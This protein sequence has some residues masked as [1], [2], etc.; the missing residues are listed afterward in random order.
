MESPSN[1]AGQIMI[2]K[3]NL[4]SP[5]QRNLS[6]SSSSSILVHVLRCCECGFE[7]IVRDRFDTHNPCANTIDSF[8]LYTCSRCGA[9]STSQTLM[10]EHGD[11]CHPEQTCLI[12]ETIEPFR[13]NH[14]QSSCASNHRER[15]LKTIKPK[16]SISPIKEKLC[17]TQT[18]GPQNEALSND[19]YMNSFKDFISRFNA[20]GKQMSKDF[21]FNA[22]A[23]A[24]LS[25]LGH[26]SVCPIC[27]QSIGQGNREEL[28]KHLAF[29]HLL[30]IPSILNYFTATATGMQIGQEKASLSRLPVLETSTPLEC[31]E[32][33]NATR[34]W[35]D[36]QTNIPMSPPL[37][38]EMGNSSQSR[39]TERILKKDQTTEGQNNRTDKAPLRPPDEVPSKD[40]R[41]SMGPNLSCPQCCAGFSNL[42]QLQLHFLQEHAQTLE[43]IFHLGNAFSAGR[44]PF[45]LPG[46][47]LPPFPY[48]YPQH[49]PPK[50]DDFGPSH[51]GL[52]P[53]QNSSLLQPPIQHTTR[54]DLLRHDLAG[55]TALNPF[56]SPPSQMMNLQL[57]AAA[58]ALGFPFSSVLIPDGANNCMQ[59]EKRPARRGDD[60]LLDCN[61]SRVINGGPIHAEPKRARIQTGVES[62]NPFTQDCPPTG[63]TSSDISLPPWLYNMNSAV[64]S[65]TAHFPGPTT[66]STSTTV[67]AGSKP[68]DYSQYP[69]S[70]TDQLFPLPPVP[71]FPF[72]DTLDPFQTVSA[73]MQQQTSN[74]SGSGGKLDQPMSNGSSQD[75]ASTHLAQSGGRIHSISSLA[76]SGLSQSLKSDSLGGDSTNDTEATS[77]VRLRPSAKGTIGMLSKAIIESVPTRGEGQANTMNGIVHNTLRKTRS[78]MKVIHRYL[79]QVKH[80]T[81][82]IHQ[83]PYYELDQYIQDFVLTAKKK[84]GHEYEPESLKAFVHSLER[85]LK[86]HGYPH[87]VL[88]GTAFTGTRT[89]LNQRLNE[90]RALSRSSG[91]STVGSYPSTVGVGGVSVAGKRPLDATVEILAGTQPNVAKRVASGKSFTPVGLIQAGLLGKD[92]PQA[93][94]NSLWL[95]NRT[96]FNIGGTQRHRNLVWGQFQLITDDTGAKAI[97]FTPLFE[98]AEVRYCR[99]YGGSKGA[100]VTC[101]SSS[102]AQTLSCTGAAKRQPLPFNCVELFELYANLRP[103]EARGVSEPFYLCPD[104]GWEQNRTWFKTNAAGSQLLSRIPRLLGLKPTR[105]PIQPIL[106]SMISS[107]QSHNDPYDLNREGVFETRNKLHPISIARSSPSLQDKISLERQQHPPALSGNFPSLCP[108]TLS[109]NI[110]H[111]F[112]FMFPPTSDTPSIPTMGSTQHPY[113]LPPNIYSALSNLTPPSDF[114]YPFHTKGSK[115]DT[116]LEQQ[117]ADDLSRSGLSSL[118]NMGKSTESPEQQ[119]NSSRSQH[120]ADIATSSSD[121]TPSPTN[122]ENLSLSNASP[123][124]L[125]PVL[126]RAHSPQQ[127]SAHQMTKLQ[128]TSSTICT[129]ESYSS[130]NSN[131][132]HTSSRP[133]SAASPSNRSAC[134]CPAEHKV[135]SSDYVRSTSSSPHSA[136]CNMPTETSSNWPQDVLNL[137]HCK[138]EGSSCA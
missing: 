91:G 119:P 106:L 99:G 46:P 31:A 111:L 78:D 15:Q 138:Q 41:C 55:L 136:G 60:K 18:S 14:R 25:S 13:S 120:E 129:V 53:L 108:P 4:T 126:G 62:T 128:K 34:E 51:Q 130:P 83:I 24:T 1:S 122:A 21:L 85:H 89:V 93:I 113:F 118:R 56:S 114:D 133:H 33:L 107:E 77:T 112:P 19:T 98:S 39:S 92:N 36:S 47:V 49:I 95:I 69:A 115:S 12:E 131:E 16:A 6:T 10:N 116:S 127:D 57:T 37:I 17:T 94:L 137:A 71:H 81:R 66:T 50:Q 7:T 132:S 88:K 8:R 61:P 2:T 70:R 124:L 101:R 29:V 117:E 110:F 28:I 79:V 64:K 103:P 45:S 23:S 59:D 43:S 40:T 38:P 73:S 121:C 35:Y 74:S 80:D 9:C 30:P 75:N 82:D 102:S 84:D 44:F 52:N 58:H 135:V 90:L 5:C 48:P 125:C 65:R 97:K 87:S 100:D 63:A 32:R 72:A 42:H 68:T 54:S 3:D 26:D 104:P 76:L 109:P 11:L 134:S 123:M 67:H 27:N 96:Q 86:H 20:L 105:E 22:D